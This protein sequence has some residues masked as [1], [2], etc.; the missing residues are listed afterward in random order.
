MQ[1]GPFDVEP[2]TQGRTERERRVRG[3]REVEDDEMGLIFIRLVLMRTM[4]TKQH[5]RSAAEFQI[6]FIYPRNMA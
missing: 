6:L 3:G 2:T 1:I 5:D 4:S